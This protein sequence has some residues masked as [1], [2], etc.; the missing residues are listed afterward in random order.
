MQQRAVIAVSIV[1]SGALIAEAVLFLNRATSLEMGVDG[2]NVSV[3]DGS[4]IIEIEAKAGYWPRYTLA[5]ADMPTV[6]RI[7]TNGT[8]DC[9]L[10]LTIPAIGYYDYLPSF[11]VTDIQVPPQTAGT[12]LRGLCTMAGMYNFEVWFN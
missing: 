5:G 3:V 7:L 6:L 4:Q 8:F 12:V 1:I 11:G 2:S 10:A 9:S